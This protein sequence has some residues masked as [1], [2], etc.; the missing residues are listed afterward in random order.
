MFSQTFL[1]VYKVL[2]HFFFFLFPHG[3]IKT[4]AKQQKAH[5]T[6]NRKQPKTRAL[7]GN[8]VNRMKIFYLNSGYKIKEPQFSVKRVRSTHLLQDLAYEMQMQE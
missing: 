3:K 4:K 1:T 2:N 8:C 6:T 5:H 7:K